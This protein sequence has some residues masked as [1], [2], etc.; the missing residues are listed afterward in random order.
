MSRNYKFYNQHQPYFITC[1]VINWLNV[2]TETKYNTIVLDSLKY[3][4][5]HKGL[6]IYG[7]CIMPSHLHLIIGTN[8]EPMQFIIRDFK[9]FTSRHIRKRM[10][11]NLENRNTQRMVQKMK[12]TGLNNKN[13][14]DWQFWQQHSHPQELFY[15]KV[16]EQKL[17]YIHFNPVKAGLTDIPKNWLYSSARDYAGGKGLLDIELLR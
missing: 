7:W 4:Q 12:A 5:K 11:E 17:N 10:E 15:K 9:S 1:T 6:L 2:F 3:C 14:K 13:N 8:N 16:A